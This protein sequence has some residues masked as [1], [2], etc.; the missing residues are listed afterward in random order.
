MTSQ[1]F[2]SAADGSYYVA[3][4]GIALHPEDTAVPQRPDSTYQ[5]SNG[6]WAQSA[7]L[8]AAAVAAQTQAA[9]QQLAA[10]GSD[11][12]LSRGLEDLVSLLIT[13]GTIAKT[14]L[15]A[16]LL[17]KIDNRRAVRGQAAL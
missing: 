3:A 7:T 13:K 12:S 6:A 14:D 10:Q 15:P 1:A 5:W 8:A 17:T 4:D 16:A 2:I 9:I 11:G